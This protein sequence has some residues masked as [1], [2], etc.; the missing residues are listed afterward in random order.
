MLGLNF[1]L[2]GGVKRLKTK[3]YYGSNWVESIMKFTEG[4]R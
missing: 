2:D 3:V 1:S 4:G